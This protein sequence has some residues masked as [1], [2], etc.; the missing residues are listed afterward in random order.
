MSLCLSELNRVTVNDD[1]SLIKDYNP[2]LADMFNDVD[3]DT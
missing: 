3:F 1:S 2:C